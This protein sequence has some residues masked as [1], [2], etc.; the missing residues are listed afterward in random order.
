VQCERHQPQ[1]NGAGVASLVDDGD[2]EMKLQQ[3]ILVVV[4]RWRVA[5]NDRTE[6]RSS[7]RRSHLLRDQ[8]DQATLGQRR[9]KVRRREE[10]FSHHRSQMLRMEFGGVDRRVTRTR[11]K[12]SELL[13]ECAHLRKQSGIAHSQPLVL[14]QTAGRASMQRPVGRPVRHSCGKKKKKKKKKKKSDQGL[15]ERERTGLKVSIARQLFI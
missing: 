6:V 1:W 14:L 10:I 4:G 8:F 2:D 11:P 3:A 15:T 12:C 7:S 9:D 5:S 13:G